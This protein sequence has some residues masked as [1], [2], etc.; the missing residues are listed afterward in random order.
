MTAENPKAT[1]ARINV[2]EK[3]CHEEI[4]NQSICINAD[5]KAVINKIIFLNTLV[6]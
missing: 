2:G 5:I 4:E 3:I 1:Y 6:Y